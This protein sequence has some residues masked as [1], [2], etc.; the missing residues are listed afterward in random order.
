MTGYLRRFAGR[1]VAGLDVF[2][3]AALGLAAVDIVAGFFVAGL[4]FEAFIPGLLADFLLAEVLG[5][6]PAL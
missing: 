5:V 1:F 3:D 6:A 2:L 4:A